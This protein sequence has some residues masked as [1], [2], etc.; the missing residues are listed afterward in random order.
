MNSTVSAILFDLGG[1]LVDWDGVGPLR[2]LTQGRLSQEQARRFWLESPWV[3]KFEM[4]HCSAEAFGAGVVEELQLGISSEKFLAAFKSWDRGL[5][6]GAFELLRELKPRYQLYCL[7]NNNPLHWE[8]SELQRLLQ[9]FSRTFVSFEIGLIKPDLA[10]FEY[11]AERLPEPPSRVLFLDDNPECITAAIQG[12]FQA[13][14]AKGIEAARRAITD[15][16]DV[17]QL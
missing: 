2:K 14:Q 17:P 15:F 9:N 11:V 4:G 8:S 5:F 7:S 6:P 16:G 3:R 12:G 10:V 1:V 13:C